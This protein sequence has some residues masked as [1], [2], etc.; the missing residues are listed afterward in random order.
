MKIKGKTIKLNIVVI[1]VALVLILVYY[2]FFYSKQEIKLNL[3]YVYDPNFN[4]YNTNGSLPVV[5][6]GSAIFYGSDKTNVY[7]DA[8]SLKGIVAKD[9]LVLN[10]VVTFNIES[11]STNASDHFAIF[12]TN[13]KVNYNKEEFGF[14]LPEDS[15]ILYAYVQS[16]SIHGLF[17]PT[18]ITK[19]NN[20]ETYNL[21]AV[22]SIEDSE[23]F[24]N[25]Y[26]NNKQVWKYPFTKISNNLFYIVITSHKL[27]DPSINTSKNYMKIDNIYAR[28]Y[29]DLSQFIL[30]NFWIL[31]L[32]IVL[33][34]SL[35]TIINYIKIKIRLSSIEKEIKEL[36]QT[37]K[38][39]ETKYFN[40]AID[41]KTF[42][43][44]I[45]DLEEKRAKLESEK[46]NLKGE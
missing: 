8:V 33:V 32:G 45:K 25:F 22:Y 26:L 29:V 28:N 36:I 19:V 39:L 37:R 21:K 20:G 35:G 12:L 41:E 15:N 14:F 43:S 42:H 40:R 46:R 23:P 31:I 27:S 7:Q 6:G 10:A 44:M 38:N 9:T 1:F 2:N 16:P 30:N 3:N 13:D 24:V 18:P 11:Y 5:E 4:W 17:V 34:N